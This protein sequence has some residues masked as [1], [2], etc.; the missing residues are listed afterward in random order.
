MP[1]LGI[2]AVAGRRETA[3]HIWGCVGTEV[4]IAIEAAVG[5]T[6]AGR[7]TDPPALVERELIHWAGLGRNEIGKDENRGEVMDRLTPSVWPPHRS[8]VPWAAT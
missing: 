2:Q 3:F 6:I 4:V 7:F 8:P 5:V 1:I